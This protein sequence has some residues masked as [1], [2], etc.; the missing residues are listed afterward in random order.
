MRL[1]IVFPIALCAALLAGC[2]TPGSGI[3][4]GALLGA[5]SGAAIGSMTANAGEGALIGAGV[6]A[7]GGAL[8]EQDQMRRQGY[9]GYR[10]P[11]R[12][13]YWR[14]H[15]RGYGWYAD[16]YARGPFLYGD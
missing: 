16:P 13:P 10:E 9:Y 4:G 3:A 5:A 14:S 2:G 6:G 11:Y 1:A 7:L 12:R 8:Y 15:R